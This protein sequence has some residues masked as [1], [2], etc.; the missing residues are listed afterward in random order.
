MVSSNLIINLL[1]AFRLAL[2]LDLLLLFHLWSDGL[3]R[4]CIAILISRHLALARSGFLGRS[5]SGG[6][7]HDRLTI[8]DCID[9]GLERPLELGHLLQA[10]ARV[11]ANR[12]WCVLVLCQC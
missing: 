9:L 6:V 5:I 1:L 4:G 12:S 3:L 7:G 10:A 8:L 11:A 2:D